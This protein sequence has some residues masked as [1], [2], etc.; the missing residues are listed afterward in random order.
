MVRIK[1]EGLLK[2]KKY[3][4]TQEMRVVR[5]GPKAMFMNLKTRLKE[6]IIDYMVD[7]SYSI[8]EEENRIAKDRR[9]DF[10]ERAM[11]DENI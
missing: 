3:S 5:G 6:R 1:A 7:M 11:K 8:H 2:L 10:I 9:T 4:N